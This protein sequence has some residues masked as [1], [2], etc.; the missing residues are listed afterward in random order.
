[1]F[2]FIMDFNGVLEKSGNLN[3]S[4]VLIYRCVGS[5]K[6]R[7][8]IDLNTSHVLIYLQVFIFFILFHIHLNTSHVLIYHAPAL[9]VE[10]CFVF[11]YISCS[12]LSPLFNSFYAYIFQFKYISCSYL[13]A[14]ILV[15]PEPFALFKY[16]SCSYLSNSGIFS[17]TYHRNLNTSHVLIYHGTSIIFEFL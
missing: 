15:F 13:S 9:L 2:L 7:K 14:A 10:C 3:T 16:I 1:M 17:G 12:Y 4:H 6:S 11:K 5:R 8:Q